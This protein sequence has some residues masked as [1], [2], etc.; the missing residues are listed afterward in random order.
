M[1]GAGTTPRQDF[2]VQDTLTYLWTSAWGW[3][4][5][6]LRAKGRRKRTRERER[7]GNVEMESSNRL[8][9][10]FA[11]VNRGK[12]ARSSSRRSVLIPLWALKLQAYP[13]DFFYTFLSFLVLYFFIIVPFPHFLDIILD[14][15]TMEGKENEEEILSSRNTI[16]LSNRIFVTTMVLAVREIIFAFRGFPSFSFEYFYFKKFPPFYSP[17]LIVLIN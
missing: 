4:Y 14:I 15:R 10:E 11:D 13:F 3:N 9:A 8:Q 12:T 7:E 1:K 5:P 17:S 16:L 2:K 6:R